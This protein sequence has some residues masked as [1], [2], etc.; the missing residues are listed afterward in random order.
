MV[1]VLIDQFLPA[2]EK[3]YIV[4]T[5]LSASGKLA[6]LAYIN[7]LFLDKI[8]FIYLKTKKRPCCPELFSEFQ[9]Y[10]PLI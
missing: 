6:H 2:K 4:T 9:S 8:K 7:Q 5:E 1:K 3:R 10:L